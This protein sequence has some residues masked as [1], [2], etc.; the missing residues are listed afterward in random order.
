MPAGLRHSAPENARFRERLQRLH[1][2]AGGVG[3]LGI[4]VF[5][6]FAFL[7]QQTQ[8]TQSTQQTL[9]PSLAPFPFAKFLDIQGDTLLFNYI[10]DKGE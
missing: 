5:G 10:I 4:R 1:A 8:S 2:D 3:Y 9:P 7:T 6:C